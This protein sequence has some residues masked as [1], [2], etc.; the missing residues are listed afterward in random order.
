MVQWVGNENKDV[1]PI[2]MCALV[3][4]AEY[5]DTG[6]QFVREIIDVFL[7][8]LRK[9]VSTIGASMGQGDRAAIA[10]AAH[11]IKGS[12]S[13]FG[14]ARLIELSRH[15]EERARRAQEPAESIQAAIEPMIAESERVRIALE[16]F[17]SSNT[18]P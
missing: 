11:A 5:D 10:A 4:L 13:H 17:R 9:R 8:D 1:A 2:D 14:A 15:V 18:G 6:F 12:C 3:Q 16:E 7:A